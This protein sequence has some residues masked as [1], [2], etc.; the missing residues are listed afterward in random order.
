MKRIFACFIA[1]GLVAC[2]ASPEPTPEDTMAEEK[3]EVSDELA[4]KVEGTPLPAAHGNHPGLE[5]CGGIVKLTDI[6]QHGSCIAACQNMYGC[7]TGRR[8][9]AYQICLCYK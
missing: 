2:G 8:E 9:T 3:T 4:R 5:H 6:K 7:P 1:L